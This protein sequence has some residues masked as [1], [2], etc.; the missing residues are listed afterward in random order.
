MRDKVLRTLTANYDGLWR[1][2]TFDTGRLLVF[3]LGAT[4]AALRYQFWAQ[5]QRHFTIGFGRNCSGTLLPVLGA[6]AAALRYRFWAQP[7]WHFTIGFV[8]NRRGTS[9]S[10]LGATAAALCYQFWAQPQRHFAIGLGRNRS[11]TS[12]SWSGL[13]GT[14]LFCMRS[15]LLCL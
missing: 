10:V 13:V 14:L 5:P 2:W 3:G 8:R 4:A 12:L 7:Q 6:I 11:G 1:S 15:D 9:L